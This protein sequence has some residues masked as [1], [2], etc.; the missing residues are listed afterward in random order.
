MHGQQKTAGE[1][2]PYLPELRR[3]AARLQQEEAAVR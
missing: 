2:L 1:H 3:V